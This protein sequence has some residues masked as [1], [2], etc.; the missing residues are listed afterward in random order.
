MTSSHKTYN[1]H[2]CGE[3]IYFDNSRKSSEGRVIPLDPATKEPH[4]HK[5]LKPEIKVEVHSKE[6]DPELVALRD[7]ALAISAM[8]RDLEIIIFLKKK[9]LGIE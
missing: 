3:P 4:Q 9:E 1:C 2:T 5:E 8:N 6:A 7:I